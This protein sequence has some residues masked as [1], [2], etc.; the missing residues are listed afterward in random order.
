[1]NKHLAI[2]TVVYENYKV[3]DDFF[4][5]LEK[6]KNQ[7]FH[8]FLVDLSNPLSHS[9]ENWNPVIKYSGFRVKHEMTM[10]RSKNLGY[11][12]G[13]NTGLKEALKQR[14]QYFCAMNNDTYFKYNFVESVLSSIFHHPSSIIGG[15]IYYAPGY[16]YHKSRYVKKDLGKVLWYAGG[17]V[18]WNHALT[19]HR[20]VDEIDK[21]Q[22]NK[23]EKTGFINGCM[24][25]FD[26][27][28]IEKVGYWDEG[29]FLYYEDADFCERA[30]QKRIELW[31]DPSIVIWHKNAQST[32]G[33]GSKLHVKYQE[34]SRLRFG[35]KYAPLKT[36]LH[37]AKNYFMKY[38]PI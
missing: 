13:I 14:Y 9:S 5:S 31:Y 15:K 4:K 25:A 38:L 12:H 20:G 35:L 8:L 18:D 2:I 24:M 22:F 17:V 30:K 33:S 28:V 1:M 32:G 36:K 11:A 10:V 37:L 21:G 26:K 29:Y 19:P 16:E 6:Q 7:S 23:V 3:L 27:E 34:K